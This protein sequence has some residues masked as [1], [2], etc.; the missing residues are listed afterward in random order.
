V[1]Y[2]RLFRKSTP[3]GAPEIQNYGAVAR[4]LVQ[5][6]IADVIDCKIPIVLVI[7]IVT[8]C[9]LIAFGFVK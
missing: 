9:A 1:R 6:P 7:T 5:I 4:R 8:S 3:A 2:D